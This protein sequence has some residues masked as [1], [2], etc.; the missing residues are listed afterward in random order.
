M[1]RRTGYM[2]K[3][4]FSPGVSADRSTTEVVPD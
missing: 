2:P 4:A 1:R 3:R